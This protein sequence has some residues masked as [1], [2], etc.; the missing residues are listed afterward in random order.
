VVKAAPLHGE[1]HGFEPHLWY[2]FAKD[3]FC[4][5]GGRDA[6]GECLVDLVVN[7]FTIAS[8][9]GHSFVDAGL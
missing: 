1:G 4:P 2:C 6:L 3:Y 9:I 8:C 5:G 7:A